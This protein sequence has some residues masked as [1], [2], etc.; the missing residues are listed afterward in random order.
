MKIIIL[1]IMDDV[2]S[3]KIHELKIEEG[4]W[5]IYLVIIFLSFYSNALERN[6][7]LYND[8]ECKKKYQEIMIIIFTV[9]LLIYIYFFYNSYKEIQNINPFDNSKKNNLIY[10][11]FIASLL[12]VISG[13]LYLYIAISDNDIDVELAFN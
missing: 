9:L 4:I 2:I 10:L 6:Y 13:I 11:A 1:C 8:I 12:L 3:K 5:I 7:F